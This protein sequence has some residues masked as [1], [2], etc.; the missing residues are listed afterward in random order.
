MPQ[1]VTTPDTSQDTGSCQLLSRSLRHPSNH[2]CQDY[3]YL[4]FLSN[5]ILI[6]LSTPTQATRLEASKIG[7]SHVGTSDTFFRRCP[8]SHFYRP[9]P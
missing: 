7:L 9:L 5:G 2:K 8:I 3:W 6:R 1:G 4:V